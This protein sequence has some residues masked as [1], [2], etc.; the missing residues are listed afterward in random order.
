LINKKNGLRKNIGQKN[1]KDE[2]LYK[3]KGSM[4]S[5]FSFKIKVIIWDRYLWQIKKEAGS[6]PLP[7]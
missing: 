4:K 1:K 3:S 5:F 6:N 7:D 2:S